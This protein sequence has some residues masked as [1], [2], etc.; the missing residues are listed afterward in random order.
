MELAGNEQRIQTLFRELRFADECIAP[1]FGEMWRRA[2]ATSPARLRV[3][4][5]AFAL[6]LPLAVIAL[7][8]LALWSRN[9]YRL[10]TIAP[11]VVSVSGHHGSP[12]LLPS[13]EA[14]STS[15][16]IAQ[17]H[18]KPGRANRTTRK[19]VVRHRSDNG[20]PDAT[21]REIVAISTWK[22]PTAILLQ[23]P[24]D[25]MLTTLP[26][27]DLSARNLKTFLPDTLQ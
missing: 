4:K 11:I 24:A 25:D 26:Q 7:G 6:S 16:V 14:A 20:V 23:S 18:Y 17:S 21:A 10:Q 2:Q 1:E 3:H 13:V 19:L 9:S 15:L 27:L 5:L 22:S 12:H 8:S